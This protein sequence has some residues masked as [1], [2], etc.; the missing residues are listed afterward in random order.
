MKEKN[1]TNINQ[2]IALFLIRFWLGIRVLISGI[3]KFS[4][5][6]SGDQPVT[7]DGDENSYGLTEATSSKTYGLEFY[8]GIPDSLK[9]KFA[10]EPLLPEWMLAPFN[11]VLGPLLI[12][13]G[14]TILLGIFTRISLFVLGL[15]FTALTVGLVLIK[16]DAG[17]AWLG[18]HIILIATA[19]FYSD[20]DRLVLLKSRK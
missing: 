17:V 3:E 19:L 13:L 8:S 5:T 4:G 12:V 18:I 1:Y 11:L 7:I 14:I 9:T 6:V 15:V 10:G 16:Q 2:S 20:K